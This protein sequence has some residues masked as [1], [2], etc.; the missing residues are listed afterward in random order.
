M[1][2]GNGEPATKEA[3]MSLCKKAAMNDE[4]RSSARR[5]GCA[6]ARRE[7]CLTERTQ[8]CQGGL[9]AWKHDLYDQGEDRTSDAGKVTLAVQG[10][11]VARAGSTARTELGCP[12]VRVLAVY[13]DGGVLRYQA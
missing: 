1:A 5:T 7:P 3:A 12:I 9:R 11:V 10:N 13:N 2:S 4:L 8:Q 6:G